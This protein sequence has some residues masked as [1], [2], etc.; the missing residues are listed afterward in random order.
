MHWCISGKTKLWVLFIFLFIRKR[1]VWTFQGKIG[2]SNIKK[3]LMACLGS[4]R[5][6]PH[7]QD[8]LFPHAKS[9]KEKLSQL[10]GELPLDALLLVVKK[11]QINCSIKGT[12]HERWEILVLKIHASVHKR[13]K[14]LRILYSQKW[15]DRSRQELHNHLYHLCTLLE[16]RQK[17]HGYNIANEN[18]K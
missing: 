12:C 3:V 4:R 11:L 7:L 6:C 18:N 8:S 16:A 9:Y 5:Q 14:K 17:V 2:Y 10:C 13:N 15:R 1:I